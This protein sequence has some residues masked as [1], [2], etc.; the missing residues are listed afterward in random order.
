MER[1]KMEMEAK[2][3]EERKVMQAGRVQ[4]R[5][6]IQ[7][8]HAREKLELEEQIENLNNLLEQSRMMNRNTLPEERPR[9]NAYFFS[10]W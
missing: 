4:E 5:E 8:K 9:S 2:H 1:Q 10:G 6:E 3:A 7:A